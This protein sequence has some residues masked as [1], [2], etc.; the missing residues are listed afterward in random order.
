MSEPKVTVIRP[1]LT[2]E[3]R[4][5]RMKL[6]EQCLAQ[7]AIAIERGK[8]NVHSESAGENQAVYRVSCG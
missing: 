1:D 2:P 5:K 3:E 8:K 6:L 4:E 7:F